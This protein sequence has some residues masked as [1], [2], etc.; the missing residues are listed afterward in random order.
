L[1]SY[2]AASVAEPLTIRFKLYLRW[3]LGL[4]LLFLMTYGFTNW[5]A[6]MRSTR[7]RLYFGWELAIPFVPWMIWVYLSMQ[8]FLALPL[9]LLNTTGISRFGR[10]IALATL[11]A[12]AI[13]LTLPTDLGWTRPVAVPGY[14]VFARCFAMDQPHN[15]VPSLHVTFS[16]LS[17]L[18]IWNCARRTWVK[19]L[20]A[21]WFALLVCSVLLIH[22]HHLVDIV[23]GLVLALLCNRWFRIGD[24]AS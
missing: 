6:G 10:T 1:V 22:Q 15:L 24:A 17:F 3:S 7:F 8:A 11:A 12:F 5:L 9:F 2:F 23:T 21:A 4:T 14:P 18:V 19:L 13:H 16:A 20:S